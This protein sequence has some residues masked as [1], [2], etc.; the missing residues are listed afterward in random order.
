MLAPLLTMV[1][2]QTLQLRLTMTRRAAPREEPA[3][4][5]EKTA[6]V[7]DHVLHLTALATTHHRPHPHSLHSTPRL[8]AAGGVRLPDKRFIRL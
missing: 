3:V 4:N 5:A 6:T 1:L 7:N 2:L 8:A